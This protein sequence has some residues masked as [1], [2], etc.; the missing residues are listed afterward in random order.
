MPQQSKT[1]P[2]DIDGSIHIPVE[3]G[4]AAGTG[5]AALL[6]HEIGIHRPAY[7]TRLAGWHPPIDFYDGITGNPLQDGHKFRKG[8]VRNLSSPQA[9]HAIRAVVQ[10]EKVLQPKI[11]PD[12]LTCSRIDIAALLLGDNDKIDFSQC[13]ALYGNRFDGSLYGAGFAVFVF[14]PHNSDLVAR[15]KRIPRLLQGEAGVTR[16]LFKRGR[17]LFLH[18]SPSFAQSAVGIIISDRLLSS[19]RR[20]IR[21]W[22]V[23]TS[24]RATGSLASPGK[25]AQGRLPIQVCFSRCP[26]KSYPE[27]LGLSINDP[28]AHDEVC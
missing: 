1:Q 7:M 16:L 2:F 21:H 15:L 19:L 20:I 5:P 25:P 14:P 12:S 27:S 23:G 4:M 24:T 8:K 26:M 6:Q 9:F 18:D 17:R 11:Y 13:I 10:I 22:Y 28:T 3:G